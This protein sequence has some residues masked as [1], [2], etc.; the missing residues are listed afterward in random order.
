MSPPHPIQMPPMHRNRWVCVEK[1]AC[2]RF[3]RTSRCRWRTIEDAARSHA[4]LFVRRNFRLPRIACNSSACSHGFLCVCV[5]VGI[6]C[7]FY[8]AMLSPRSSSRKTRCATIA[9]TFWVINYS[10]CTRTGA[11]MV[12][13]TDAD[14]GM[15]GDGGAGDGG[16]AMRGVAFAQKLP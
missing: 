1:L 14:G 8:C 12:H 6:H 4:I 9:P 2:P 13:G 3:P 7:I 11:S 15:R 5:A 10:S 16:G